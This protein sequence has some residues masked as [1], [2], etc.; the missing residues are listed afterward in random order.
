MYDTTQQQ[1]VTGKT[2]STFTH[3]IDVADKATG[4]IWCTL[5]KVRPKR[6]TAVVGV[7]SY[8]EKHPARYAFLS[9]VYK[10]VAAHYT[11]QVA[12]MI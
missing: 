12:R 2:A 4:T 7:L 9:H 5:C 1:L 3:A 8:T 10:V 11:C 6:A